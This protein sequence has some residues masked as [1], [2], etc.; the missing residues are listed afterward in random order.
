MNR[1]ENY[2]WLGPKRYDISGV[3]TFLGNRG[4]D[5][6]ISYTEAEGVSFNIHDQC[7]SNCLTCQKNSSNCNGIAKNRDQ[8]ASPEADLDDSIDN[9][10]IQGMPLINGTIL[11]SF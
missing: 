8:T 10:N 3:R 4:Y 9:N 11:N 1:S 5:G 7:L 2:R 6:S